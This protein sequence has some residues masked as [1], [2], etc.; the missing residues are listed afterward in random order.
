MESIEERI[1]RV[2][3]NQFGLRLDEVR[4]DVRFAEDLMVESIEVIELISALEDELG[5]E[6]PGDMIHRNRTVGELIEYLKKRLAT[7]S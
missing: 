7:S 4:D 1:K 6:M 5:M 2:I 3:A